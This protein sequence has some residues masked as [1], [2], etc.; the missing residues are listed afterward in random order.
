MDTQNIYFSIDRIYECTN[1]PIRFLIKSHSFAFTSSA[2]PPLDDPLQ[3]DEAL[4][5]RL[6]KLASI[7]QEP[8]L[9]IE[10]E[11]IFYG[12][13]TDDEQNC[14]IL[15]PVI[16]EPL[17]DAQLR[18]YRKMH[19]LSKSAAI[20][21]TRYQRFLATI[22]FSY[23]LFTGRQTD[24][25]SIKQA[26]ALLAD[27]AQLNV[28][29]L[30]NV[31]QEPTE[32]GTPQVS[33]AQEQESYRPIREGDPDAIFRRMSNDILHTITRQAQSDSKHYEYLVCTAITLSARA[34]IQGGL[35]EATAYSL[36][37]LG[38]RRLEKCQ[39]IPEYISLLRDTMIGFAGCVKDAKQDNAK[40]GYIEQ[41]IAYIN[42]HLST[43]FTLQD[44]ADD[45]GISPVYLSRR[46]TE[47][48]GIGMKE[49]TKRLRLDA[50]SNMLRYSKTDIS[51]I[52][53]HLC[54]SSQSYFG[55]V[56]KRYFGITPQKYR[57]KSERYSQDE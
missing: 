26:N 13:F 41:S 7:A 57:E 50:A 21:K 16:C 6:I 22:V 8:V 40:Q 37:N 5:N 29:D 28:M 51:D 53:V 17:S 43:P 42:N 44:I 11:N 20:S 18:Q 23:Y 36:E 19:Q 54:Y 27:D 4:R 48:V 9:E 35:N 3:Q 15:G 47:V 24:Q 32:T 52:A 25:K 30:R 45:I 31:Q 1:I 46:F 38:K 56:F 14:V 12:M 33:Y 49:Y 34:A 2:Y 39:S 10:E 55:S